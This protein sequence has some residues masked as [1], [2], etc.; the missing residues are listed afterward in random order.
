MK[1]NK[2]KHKFKVIADGKVE[3]CGAGIGYHSVYLECKCGEVKEL[4]INDEK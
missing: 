3:K 1:T 2:H 4:R